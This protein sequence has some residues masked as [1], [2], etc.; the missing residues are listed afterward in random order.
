MR[1]FFL[2]FYCV[3]M[4]AAL[5]A[6]HN[7]ETT[8]EEVAPEE[9]QTPVTVTHIEQVPLIEYTDLNATS[10]YLQTNFIKASANGY[11][12]LVNV[13]KGQSVNAGQLVFKLKTKEA[14]ALGNT[15]N[16]LDSSFHF[17]G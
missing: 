4:V 14:E 9:V 15:I 1:K 12:K 5:F 7:K 13:H 17:S 11:L 3:Y 2:Y 6:C 10:T 8:T 16:T